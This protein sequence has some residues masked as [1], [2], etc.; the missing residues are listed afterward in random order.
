MRP[1]VLHQ[2]KGRAGLLDVN[3]AI[4]QACSGSNQQLFTVDELLAIYSGASECRRKT[5]ENY[6]QT[7]SIYY[8]L[9][10]L[11]QKNAETEPRATIPYFEEVEA[12]G[13]GVLHQYLA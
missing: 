11:S 10:S 4:A 13:M 9:N 1:L 5:K 8:P 3:Q 2:Q 7:Y 12:R 6:K